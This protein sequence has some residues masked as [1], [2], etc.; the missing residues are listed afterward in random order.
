M[1][2]DNKM[3]LEEVEWRARTGLVCPRIGTNGGLL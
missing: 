2:N 1:G 3:D